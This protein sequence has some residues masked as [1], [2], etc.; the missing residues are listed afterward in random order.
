MFI[1]TLAGPLEN[2]KDI[3]YRVQD[4]EL[5]KNYIVA[6]Y[7]R[8]ER[9]YKIKYQYKEFTIICPEFRKDA[10]GAEPVVIIPEFIVH[11]R[12]YP[13]YVYL[14]AI[15][16]YSRTS[17]K[18]QRWAAEQ[19]RKRFGLTTFAH[20]TLGRAIKTFVSII[21]NNAKTLLEPGAKT[22]ADINKPSFPTVDS[23]EPLRKYA[24]QFL[25]EKLPRRKGLQVVDAYCELVREWF[26]VNKC[27]LL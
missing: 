22:H 19:T 25:S 17:E 4:K 18:G 8:S 3:I 13:V 15:D 20:T 21:G 7:Q 16:L 10:E 23:T 11:G 1:L 5:E 6:G 9:E 26:M 12:P 24:M 27:F 14:Y 2:C